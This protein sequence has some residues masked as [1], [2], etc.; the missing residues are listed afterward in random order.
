MSVSRWKHGAL[1][2]WWKTPKW[3]RQNGRTGPSR[4]IHCWHDE[5]Q[6]MT[7]YNHRS[8]CVYSKV[9]RRQKTQL[10][11]W[12]SVTHRACA[13]QQRV[14]LSPWQHVFE[15]SVPAISCNAIFLFLCCCLVSLIFGGV[16][17]LMSQNWLAVIFHYNHRQEW[18]TC[19]WPTWGRSTF[20]RLQSL[21]VTLPLNV[22]Y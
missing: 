21:W 19:V 2:H 4:V 20:I 14:V 12:Y 17:A 8:I 10:L 6:I 11:G 5:R 18:L 3:A 15:W 9:G 13:A 22:F 16:R 1:C 7:A